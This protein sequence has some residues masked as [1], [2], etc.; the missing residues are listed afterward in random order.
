MIFFSEEQAIFNSVFK[1][2]IIISINHGR[3]KWNILDTL[4]SK[5]GPFYKYDNRIRI[6]DDFFLYL[7]L[8][9]KVVLRVFVHVGRSCLF[10]VLDILGM[11]N[12]T[13]VRVFAEFL[14]KNAYHRMPTNPIQHLSPQLIEIHRMG[15]SIKLGQSL[16]SRQFSYCLNFPIVFA[17]WMFWTKN[18][19]FL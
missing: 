16:D 5:I 15:K 19:D 1:R 4:N 14:E 11:N 9:W 12:L 2:E 6:F 18:L 3:F 10:V 7:E 17:I 8:I 13:N